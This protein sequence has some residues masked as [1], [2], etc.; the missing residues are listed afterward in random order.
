[1]TNHPRRSRSRLAQYGAKLRTI[2]GQRVVEM[3]DPNDNSRSRYQYQRY[4]DV[5][6][7]RVL[8]A[9]GETIADWA[10][11]TREELAALMHSRGEYHPI[12]DPLGL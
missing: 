11:L 10:A 3:V 8:S 5:V 2:D 6:L 7:R 9:Q 1:M 4:K 12:L